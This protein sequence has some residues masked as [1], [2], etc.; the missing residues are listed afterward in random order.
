MDLEVD[1]V[2]SHIPVN[3]HRVSRY[4]KYGLLFFLYYF[5]VGGTVPFLAIWLRDVIHLSGGEIGLMFGAQAVA[6]M[7]FQPLFGV[8]TDRLDN[9]K[10][11]IWGLFI[12]L[13]LFAPFMNFIYAPLLEKSV[14]LGA[15]IGGIYLGTIFL[16]G[17]GTLEA[18]I[19]KACRANQLQYGRVRMFGGVGFG[20]AAAVSG[21]LI[22][23]SPQLIFWLGSGCAIVLA[24]LFLWVNPDSAVEAPPERA[25]KSAPVSYATIRALFRDRRFWALIIYV[26][27]VACFYEVFEQQFVNYFRSFFADPQQ[28]SRVF[29][30]V[31]TLTEFS[32]AGAMFF[33]PLLLKRIGGKKALLFAGVVMTV[34][35]LGSS[36]ADSVE[37]LVVLKLLHAIEVPLIFI[38]MFKYIEDV[39]DTR[40]S[41]TIYMVGF[42]FTRGVGVTL[43]SSPIGYLYDHFGFQDAYLAMG[44]IVLLFTI[45]AAFTLNSGNHR[46]HSPRHPRRPVVAV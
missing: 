45:I 13:V 18:W 15:L 11:L 46:D 23:D 29:G 34:R 31:T 9:R 33:I 4:F 16:A 8:I 32:V 6:A 42:V 38:G 28:G 30:F 7:L 21:L 25:G 10:H 20:T 43:F 35:I 39:F 44:L 12:M 17:A 26:V 40:L 24:L 27:G 36:L 5:I 37:M 22:S 41:A 2:P 14:L 1:I 19:E 3:R